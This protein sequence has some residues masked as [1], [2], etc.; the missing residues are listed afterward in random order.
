MNK[1][2]YLEMLPL[3]GIAKYEKGL[4]N[5]GVPFAGYPRVHPS[6]KTKLIL[7]NDP[8]GSEPT[9]LEFK[10]EDILYVDEIPSA[11]TEAG[12]GVPMI[13][14]WVQR[15]AIGVILEPFEVNDPIQF[16][17]KVRAVKERILQ[18]DHTSADFSNDKKST[19]VNL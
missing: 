1:I 11:V 7:V 17:G 13:K 14:L 4:H 9:V 18:Y 2:N 10:L 3:S 8:L 15:G 5:D 16:A 6:D 12:E 19:Q